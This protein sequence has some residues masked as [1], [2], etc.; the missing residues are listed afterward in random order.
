MTPAKDPVGRAL[1]LAPVAHLDRIARLHVLAAGL[2]G[3]VVRERTID[4]PFGDVWDFVSDL[5][6]AVPQFDRDVAKL[7][8]LNRDG[9]RLRIRATGSARLLWIPSLF[10][11]DLQQGWCWMVSRPQ[12]YLVGMAAEPEGGGGDRTRFAHLEGVAVRGARTVQRLLRPVYAVSAWRHAHHL[13]HDLDNI[14][15]LVEAGGGE[16]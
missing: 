14:Q 1:D 13:P 8:V 11:V 3:V 15:R 2:P 4:A 16:R 7:R 10:D 9:D 5:E 6:R 12:A